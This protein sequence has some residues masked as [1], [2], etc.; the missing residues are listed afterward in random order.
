MIF[1]QIEK[2]WAVFFFFF[3]LRFQQSAS[4]AHI[5]V[6]RSCLSVLRDPG[7][8]IRKGGMAF[9][10]M[11]KRAGGNGFTGRYG[12]QQG[13][14]NLISRNG[15]KKGGSSRIDGL[16]KISFIFHLQLRFSSQDPRLT[17]GPPTGPNSTDLIFSFNYYPDTLSQT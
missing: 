1:P 3:H 15:K 6:W 8:G 17:L 13:F 10:G 16:A 5:A 12:V 4:V 2:F 14:I 11:G 9:L 7:L